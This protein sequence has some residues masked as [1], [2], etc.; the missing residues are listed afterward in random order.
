M[1][2]QQPP[3]GWTQYKLENLL[4][5]VTYNY[6]HIKSTAH[7]RVPAMVNHPQYDPELKKALYGKDAKLQPFEDFYH[8]ALY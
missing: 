6:N 5:D 2:K 3:R 7:H 4:R 8:E 1:R